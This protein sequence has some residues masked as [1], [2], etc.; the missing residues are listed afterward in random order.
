MRGAVGPTGVPKIQ[1]MP[2]RI[3]EMPITRMI[4]PVTTGG[5]KRSSRLMQR[6][7]AGCAMTP[8]PMIAPKISR[9]PSGPGLARPIETIGPTRGEGHAHHH[10]QLD[11]EVAGRRRR[12][13]GSRRCRR[14]RGRPRSGRR[15][16]PAASLSTRPTISGTAMAPAYITSTCW[17]PRVNSFG[18]GSISSTGWVAVAIGR[19]PGLGSVLAGRGARDSPGSWGE[20]VLV[21]I[22]LLV[23]L[24]RLPD[25]NAARARACPCFVQGRRAWGQ[26]RLPRAREGAATDRRRRGPRGACS[27]LR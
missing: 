10:R 23:K 15:R 9:A 12:T 19:S 27:R 25:Q 4:V 20:R 5:K 16:P 14:R 21:S 17:R 1:L 3:S 11:A 8:A 6:R 13:A 7:D 18:A 22:R 24:L 26:F 2:M